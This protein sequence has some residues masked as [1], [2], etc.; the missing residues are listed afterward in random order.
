MCWL[1][2][3]SKVNDKT[4]ITNMFGEISEYRGTCISVRQLWILKSGILSLRQLI[5]L[6]MR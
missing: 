3:I 2:I 5:N 6:I 1:G 4:D